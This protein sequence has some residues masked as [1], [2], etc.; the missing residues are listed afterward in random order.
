M[1]RLLLL[2]GIIS[3]CAV[4]MI[5]GCSDSATESELTEGN[6]DDPNFQI[7]RTMTDGIVDSLFNSSETAFGFLNFDGTAPSSVANDT[8]YVVFHESSCWWEIYFSIDSLNNWLVLIDSLQFRNAEGCQQFPDSLTTTEI[9]YRIYFDMS[10]SD[11]S[12]SID[13]TGHQIFSLEGI[14]DDTVVVNATTQNNMDLAMGLLDI[15]YEYDAVLTGLKFLALDL[16]EETEP[17]PVS[18]SL[19]LSLSVVSSSP[20]ASG[21]INWSITI[22]FNP[23]GYHAR[24]ESGENYWEWDVTYIT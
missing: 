21:S 16:E 23:T 10:V 2:F 14:Q 17:R 3:L 13:A 7:A 15:L 12:A 19:S 5:A 4:F 6:P 22:T 20:N 9:E 8:L 1:K 24:A 11:D 18:G